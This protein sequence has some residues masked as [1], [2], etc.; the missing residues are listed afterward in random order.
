MTNM[1]QGKEGGESGVEWGLTGTGSRIGGGKGI[2][3]KGLTK[4]A[5]SSGAKTR[6]KR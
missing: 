2:E 6:E 4:R 1:C 3:E 5:V